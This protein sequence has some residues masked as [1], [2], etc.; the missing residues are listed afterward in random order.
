MLLDGNVLTADRVTCDEID[1]RVDER[2]TEF[3]SKTEDRVLTRR[4]PFS[5]QLHDL[6]VLETLRPDSITSLKDH[7]LPAK[8]GQVARCGQPGEPGADDHNSL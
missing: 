1:T 6:A 7:D 8:P 2:E 4:D 3:G 5:T